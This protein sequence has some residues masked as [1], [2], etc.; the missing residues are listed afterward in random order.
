M[1][2]DLSKSNMPKLEILYNRRLLQIIRSHLIEHQFHNEFVPD[3]NDYKHEYYK[4]YFGVKD[5]KEFGY[6]CFNLKLSRK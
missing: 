4:E 5:H 1:V 6:L 3:I 2:I